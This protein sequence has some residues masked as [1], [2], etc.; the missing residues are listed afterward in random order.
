MQSQKEDPGNPEHL[1]GM[2]R[3]K[4]TEQRG[5]T[6]HLSDT[7]LICQEETVFPGGS[8]EEQQK[9][10]LLSPCSPGPSDPFCKVRGAS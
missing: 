9:L 6:A 3:G 8:S 10:G 7:G 2:L 5:M 1:G 4:E